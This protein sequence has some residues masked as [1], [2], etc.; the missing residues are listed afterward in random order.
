MRA[1]SGSVYVLIIILACWIGE[2]GIAVLASLFSILGIIEFHKMQFGAPSKHLFLPIYNAI[3]GVLL[4]LSFLVYPFFFWLLWA[5]GRMIFTIY[6]KHEH[7]EKEFAVDMAA[8]IYIGLPMALL[9]GLGFFCQELCNSCMPILSIFIL[10]WINDTGAFLFGST[11][12]KHKLFPRVSPKKSWEGFWGGC[13]TTIGVAIL[14]GATGTPL[15]AEYLGDKITFWAI[16]G[17]IVSVAATFGDL[18]ESVIKRNLHIKDSGNIMPGHGGILDRID[19]LLLVVPAI[20]VFLAFYSML[21]LEVLSA[22][23]PA[24]SF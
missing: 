13:L 23:D 12:G 19:S 10:I 21:I 24:F 5:I 17:L 6:S 1:A 9:V 22:Y 7:P 18:F 20:V 2:I 14:I 3:G 8:Q 15:S 4:T 16:T 11:L